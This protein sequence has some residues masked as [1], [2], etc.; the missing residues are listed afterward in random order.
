MYLCALRAAPAYEYARVLVIFKSGAVIVRRR[1]FRYAAVRVRS[2]H[3]RTF[4]YIAILLPDNLPR[5]VAAHLRRIPGARV[6]LFL[7]G[8]RKSRPSC[9]FYDFTI[10][11]ARTARELRRTRSGY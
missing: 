5:P 3:S 9:H 11:V 1:I 4:A 7:V 6:H 8:A 10:E 2:I